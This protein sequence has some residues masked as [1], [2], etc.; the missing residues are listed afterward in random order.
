MSS[1]VGHRD[2]QYNAVIRHHGNT[3]T[4]NT[5]YVFSINSHRIEIPWE[6]ALLLWADIQFV[7]DNVGAE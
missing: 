1:D 4:Y 3:P 7:R 6:Q 5:P 2:W